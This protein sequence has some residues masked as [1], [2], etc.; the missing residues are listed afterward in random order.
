MYSIEENRLMIEDFFNKEN[1]YPHIVLISMNTV[2]SLV[3]QSVFPNQIKNKMI[4][5]ARKN[6]DPI[7]KNATILQDIIYGDISQS[8]LEQMYS[9]LDGV[10][11]FL[12]TWIGKLLLP[13]FGL[14]RFSLRLFFVRFALG[15]F[16]FGAGLT[17]HA[18]A[19]DIH[20]GLCPWGWFG[21]LVS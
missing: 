12:F 17:S 3:V 18:R 7:G 11:F 19:I 5:L 16:I 15:L 10:G 21:C 1:S 8:P 13:F 20:V 4:F 6:K 14:W 9:I 2:G